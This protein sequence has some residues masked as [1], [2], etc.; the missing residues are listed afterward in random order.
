MN[1]TG[2]QPD[3]VGLEFRPH[4]PPFRLRVNDII[5][6]DEKRL[7]RVI[8]VTDCSA[9]VEVLRP[10]RTFTT[11]FDKVVRLPPTPVR[12]RISPNSETD[13][14]NRPNGSHPKRKHRSPRVRD[15]TT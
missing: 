3:L 5:R 11:R 7:G 10:A 12:F 4:R 8:R 1:E 13:I 6:V 2:T 9:V 15:G 14:L